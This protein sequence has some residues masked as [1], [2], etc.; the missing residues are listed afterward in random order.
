M[1][2]R[3]QPAA[4]SANGSDDTNLTVVSSDLTVKQRGAWV[5]ILAA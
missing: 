5:G 3:A 1:I 4:E 2:D